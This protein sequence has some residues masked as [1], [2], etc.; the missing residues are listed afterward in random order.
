MIHVEGET[1]ETFVNEILKPHLQK[2]GY[3]NVSARLLGNA[4]QRDRRGGIRAWNNVRSDII[5]HLKE[6]PNCYATT[7]VDYY[8]LPQDKLNA[9]PG[10]AEATNL[11][12][13]QK[14]STIENSLSEDICQELGQ[15]FN[16][17]RFV[18]FILMHE[19][20]ALLF[21]NCEA[22]CTGI[23]KPELADK[24]QAIR[25]QFPSPEEINDSPT[26]APSKRVESLILGYQKPL[27]GV[28]A[29]LEIGLSTIRS[30]CAHFRNWL[31]KLENPNRPHSH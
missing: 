22:F 18:P 12:F 4:R 1:E 21:S 15:N 29:A 8:A 17:S 31:E 9:W 20:E 28:V 13:L 14:A 11:P 26:T 24:F 7:M 16:A 19:F 10:R 23:G 27:Y 6:D 5:R 3:E 25:D 30:E 2:F